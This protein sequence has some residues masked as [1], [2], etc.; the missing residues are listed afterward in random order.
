MAY[1]E[2]VIDDVLEVL[3]QL[4]DELPVGVAHLSIRTP[5]SG[6]KD[7]LIQPANDKAAPIAVFLSTWCPIMI[8]VGK[9][10]PIEVSPDRKR[11]ELQVVRD[12]CLSIIENGAAEDLWLKGDEIV[13]SIGYVW[14]HGRQ[15][16]IHRFAGLMV[17]AR[18]ESIHYEP[19]VSGD[20]EIRS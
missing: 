1:S 13:R 10:I 15:H 19:Y 3:R 8:W 2:N 6:E 16:K 20:A 12:T 4:C 18:K 5:A 17:G 9:S 7:V 14:A 11:T